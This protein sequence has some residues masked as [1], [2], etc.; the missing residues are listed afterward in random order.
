MMYGKKRR[1]GTLH[2]ARII[3]DLNTLLNV[4]HCTLPAVHHPKETTEK[5]NERESM[6]N[7]ILQCGQL[8]SEIIISYENLSS[9][10]T[11]QVLI[12][13]ASFV[14]LLSEQRLI[15]INFW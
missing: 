10:T 11:V 8:K 14:T 4:F 12:K 2:V 1:L 13:K 5:M 15:L 6:G 9:K 7:I 3:F